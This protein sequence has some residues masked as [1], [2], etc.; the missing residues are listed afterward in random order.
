MDTNRT[1]VRVLSG[2][3]LVHRRLDKRQLGCVGANAAGGQTTIDWSVAQLAAALKVSRQYIDL[4]RTLSPEKR[5]AIIDGRDRTSFAALLKAPEP[6]LALPAPKRVVA[7][8]GESIDDAT[9]I[10]VVRNCGIERT[11]QAAMVVEAAQ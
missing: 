4:A 11:L 7:V 3:G 1:N 2:R 6:Q 8:N 10:A 5:Q 9:L